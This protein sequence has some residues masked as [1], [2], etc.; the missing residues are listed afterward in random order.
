VPNHV[1][2][3]LW[4]IQHEVICYALLPITVITG[5]TGTKKWRWIILLAVLFCLTVILE[6]PSS[7]ELKNSNTRFINWP[8]YLPKFFFYFALGSFV[9]SYRRSLI[10]HD[11]AAAI[12]IG[13]IFFALRF[14]GFHAIF[15]FAGTYLIFYFGYYPKYISTGA[16][17]FGDLSYGTYLYAWPVQQL[18][19]FFFMDYLTLH[20][21]FIISLILTLICAYASWNMVEEKCLRLKGVF[22]QSITG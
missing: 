20:L 12:L 15:P 10:R 7:G 19:L 5:F 16:T 14:G 22:R 13:I 1:N 21:F 2:G 4:T 9:Y 18:V 3:S 11:W 8:G 6:L 17:S